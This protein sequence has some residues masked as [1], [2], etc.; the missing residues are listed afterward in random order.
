MSLEEQLAMATNA[1]GVAP[2]AAPAQA[3][4]QPVQQQVQPTVAPQVPPVQPVTVE[5][6]TPQVQQPVNVAP[7]VPPVQPVQ[8]A[9][10]VMDLNQAQEEAEVNYAVQSIEVG[11]RISNRAIEP[12]KKLDKGE[13]V[14]ISVLNT[15]DW[16][17]YKVHNHPD[18]GKLI[19]WSTSEKLGAC[20]KDG[21]P[22]VRY[23]IPVMVYPTMPN[24]IQT[25]IPGAKCE[26]KLLILWD[27]ESYD[28][29]CQ[30]IIDHNNDVASLDLRA[31]SIDSYGKL[32]FTPLSSY[33]AQVQDQF[34]DINNKW[35]AVKD[36][37]INTVGRQLND[38]RYLRLTQTATPP[39]MA[40]YNMND[41]LD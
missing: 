23:A 6:P 25:L 12:F 15:T 41:V 29:L 22:R 39:Q 38:E 11:Q 32:L 7:Q 3:P 30:C 36:K 14:R 26:L 31:K 20:C 8:P 13:S 2:Q 35:N 9:V 27:A 37:A 34:N 33:R 17:A 5:V 19:C 4:V 18:L 40:N 21:D 24:D 16:K 1:V 10:P 28:S